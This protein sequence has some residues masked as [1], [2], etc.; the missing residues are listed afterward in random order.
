V[1]NPLNP[2]LAPQ[3]PTD[4]AILGA[5]A[6]LQSLGN[7]QNTAAILS[8]LADHKLMTDRATE[9]YAAA[10]KEAQDAAAALEGVKAQ[11]AA[12][13][14]KEQ[15]LS[16]AQT[17]LA[18]ASAANADRERALNEREA[19]LTKRIAEHEAKVKAHQDQIASVRAALT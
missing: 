1:I 8:Q 14:E 11:A 2:P 4:A 15:T 17:A 12:V 18:V 19:E 16:N 9:A 5:M 7:A 6:L 3:T 13:A 10:A